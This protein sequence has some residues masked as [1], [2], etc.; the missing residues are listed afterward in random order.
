MT[1][2]SRPS[3]LSVSVIGDIGQF[4]LFR[5]F[6]GLPKCRNFVCIGRNTE[7][8]AEIEGWAVSVSVFRQKKP[9]PSTANDC[10]QE[11]TKELTRFLRLRRFLSFS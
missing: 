2:S 9:Y 6:I 7:I 4:W 1:A 5:H 10:L 8:F 11:R 3:Y